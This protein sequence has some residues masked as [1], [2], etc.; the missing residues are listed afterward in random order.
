[1]SKRPISVIE[2][3]PLQVTLEQAEQ[4]QQNNPTFTDHTRKLHPD[5]LRE[6]YREIV[7]ETH[8][9]RVFRVHIYGFCGSVFAW[10]HQSGWGLQIADGEG[11]FNTFVAALATAAQSG[12]EEMWPN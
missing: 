1:M 6:R 11:T 9:W 8:E 5:E 10:N 4:F 3:H 12:S 7:A 2:T